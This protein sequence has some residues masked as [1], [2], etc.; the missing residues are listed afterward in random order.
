MIGLHKTKEIGLNGPWRNIEEVEFETTNWSSGSTTGGYSGR[1]GTSRRSST[2]RCTISCR[3]LSPQEQESTNPASENPGEI[4]T[5]KRVRSKERIED[6]STFYLVE[7]EN[8]AADV[9]IGHPI[10]AWRAECAA[11]T[12]NDLSGDGSECSSEVLH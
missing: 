3:R 10:V 2:E 11:I 4:Q 12:N 8:R 6:G 7:R 5:S 1:S 9:T